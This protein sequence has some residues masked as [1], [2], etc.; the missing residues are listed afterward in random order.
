MMGTAMD[1]FLLRGFLAGSAVALIAGPL[2]SF[3]VWRRMAYFGTAVSH[4]A[5]LGVV[6]GL[7]GGID[8]M[9]GVI[10]FCVASAWLLIGLE[11][12]SGL[13]MDTLIGVVSHVALAAGLVFLA[14]MGTIRIDLMGYLFGDVL[15][16]DGSALALIAGTAAVSLA[17]LIGLWRPL[18][19][20][21]VNEELAAVEGVP[22]RA[23]HVVLMTLT[24]L[25]VAIGMKIVGM[26]LI[27]SL[28]ILPPAAARPLSRSPEMM[29]ILATV[30]GVLSVGGG[31]AASY[32][33]DLQAGPTIV[34]AAGGLFLVSLL[35]GALASVRPLRSR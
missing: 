25:V 4:S 5:L 34:L 1:D 9:I 24:A 26:L 21:T 32:A 30:F 7:I 15:A 28:L 13:P 8:P 2:G 12:Q 18:L 31:L 20:L 29:A 17:L 33:F 6:L 35:A 14:A 22:V 11:R 19:A 3:I 23:L 27:V 16:V 10:A